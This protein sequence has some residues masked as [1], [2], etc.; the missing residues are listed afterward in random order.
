[1]DR[2]I[3]LLLAALAASPAWAQDTRLDEAGRH[4]QAGHYAEAFVRYASLA[5]E[6]H[7]EAAR[8]ARLMARHG[9][10]LYDTPFE[11]PTT[12]LRAWQGHAGCAGPHEDR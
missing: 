8:I 3:V 6:G 10:R 11:V 7:C 12:R 9:R 1:M 5:D 2:R 4:Y